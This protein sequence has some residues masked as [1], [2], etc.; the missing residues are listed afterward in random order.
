M[1]AGCWMLHVMMMSREEA[2]MHWEISLYYSLIRIDRSQC[3][4]ASPLLIENPDTVNRLSHDDNSN[5]YYDISVLR[6]H[7]A[8]VIVSVDTAV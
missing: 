6:L 4:C 5:I 1:F 7:R 8:G 3:V 2:K